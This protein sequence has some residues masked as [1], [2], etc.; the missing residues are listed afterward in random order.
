MLHLL[1]LLLLLMENL[2]NL[3]RRRRS[4]DNLLTGLELPRGAAGR[5]GQKLGADGGRPNADLD[6]LAGQPHDGTGLQGRAL[7]LDD[8][9]A[10]G[11]HDRLDGSG[12]PVGRGGRD[13]LDQLTRRGR[14]RRGLLLRLPEA[15]RVE[16][17]E[18]RH[19]LLRAGRLHG[20]SGGLV[21]LRV[22][23]LELREK[24]LY[25]IHS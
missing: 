22:A 14:G 18:L 6:G 11:R 20:G 9:A 13:H 25:L 12:G 3:R 8:L 4:N 15:D 23:D 7:D 24:I 10:G 2:L 19:G 17:A 5:G 21:G 1:W 16:G